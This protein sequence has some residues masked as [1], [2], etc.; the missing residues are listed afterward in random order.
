MTSADDVHRLHGEGLS[1]R[2]IANRL[3]LS[4]MKVHR[5]LTADDAH[6]WDD[7]GLA[8][9]SDD[10]RRAVP[11]FV[12]VGLAT[13]LLQLPGCDTAERMDSERFLDANGQSCSML[14]I[15]RTDGSEDKGYLDDAIRQI[16]AAGYRQAHDGSGSWHWERA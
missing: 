15:W 16:E 2:A 10:D 8:L 12:F 5:T 11:P 3:G 6:D 9:H 1:I 7:D 4:R 13:E 14:D